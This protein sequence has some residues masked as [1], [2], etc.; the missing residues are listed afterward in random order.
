MRELTVESSLF[1]CKEECTVYCIVVRSNYLGVFKGFLCSDEYFKYTKDIAHA[2]KFSSSS[3]CIDAITS[4]ADK[5]L[6]NDSYLECV[7]CV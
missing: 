3:D 4:L 1:V 2:L 6:E 7:K 5:A